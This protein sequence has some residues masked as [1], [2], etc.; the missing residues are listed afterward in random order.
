MVRSGLRLAFG[1]GR[2]VALADAAPAPVV[3]S[4]ILLEADATSGALL[5]DRLFLV[6][7]GARLA[8]LDLGDSAAALQPVELVPLLPDSRIQVAAMGNLLLVAEDHHGIHILKFRGQHLMPAHAGH[9]EPGPVL[10]AR[11]PLAGRITALAAA[12]G[13]LWIAVESG[14]EL[15]QVDLRAPSRP[16][17]ERRVYLDSPIL[18]LAGDG[19]RLH[20]LTDDGLQVLAGG[21]DGM[22]EVMERHPGLQ[23][24]SLVSSGRSLLVGSRDGGVQPYRDAEPEAA[25]FTVAVL[26]DFFSPETLTVDVGDTV[27]W[28]NAAGIHNVFSCMVGESGCTADANEVFISGIP[29]PGIWSYSYTFTSPGDNP[30][31][32]QSHAPFMTGEVTVLAGVACSALIDDGGDCSGAPAP[33]GQGYWHRQCLDAPDPGRSGRGSSEP[34]EPEFFKVLVPEVN[35]CLLD[36]GFEVD[37][38]CAGGMDAEPQR[39]PCQRALK[40]YTALLFNLASGRLH[41]GCGVDVAAW[42]CLS[43]DVGGLVTELGTLIL[44]GDATDCK[45]AAACAAAVNEG[46]ALTEAA[47]DPAGP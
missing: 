40:Q 44:S 29:F 21:D 36:L 16:V 20:A 10:L 35:D 45:R 31:V 12:G 33:L 1:S 9:E 25:T 39:D 34:G 8:A 42:G 18:A 23:G 27:R 47:P 28:R 17:L 5:R 38:A 4:R 2:E 22:W 19:T 37:G 7:D 43:T 32:C 14:G 41:E 46:E 11:F 24:A 15:L 6:L 30:Y 3:R 13:T 26:D